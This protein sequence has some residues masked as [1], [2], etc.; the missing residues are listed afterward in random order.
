MT[1]IVFSESRTVVKQNLDELNHV[2]NVVYLEFLQDVAI[3]HW[4]TAAP[5]QT[6][7]SLRWIVRKHEIEYLKPARLNDVLEVKTWVESFSGVTSH[8]FYEIS[9]DGVIIVKAN[10]I[11][12][13]IDPV[14]QKPKR[15]SNDIMSYFFEGL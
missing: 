3:H 14:S 1:P 5:A 9:I 15:L 11:W 2:N 13:A 6:I 4:H 12:I 10:T 7:E 8:R